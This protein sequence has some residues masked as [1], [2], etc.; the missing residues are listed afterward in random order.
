MRD[1]FWQWSVEVWEREPVR[2]AALAFQDRFEMDVNVLLLCCWLAESGRGAL[3]YEALKALDGALSVWA[4]TVVS[5]L[6][7]VRRSLNDHKDLAGAEALKEQVS[8]AELAAEKMA[9]G[10]LCA[11]LGERTVDEAH[12]EAQRSEDVL[13]SLVAYLHVRHLNRHDEAQAAMVALLQALYA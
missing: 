5:P 11:E 10:L 13:A 2:D 6:R 1:A 8:A 12:S 9:Q 7:A 3:D 4:D